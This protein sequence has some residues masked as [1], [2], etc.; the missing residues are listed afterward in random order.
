MLA[1]LDDPA[2]SGHTA[3]HVQKFM[4]HILT[5][6]CVT[7]EE[8][9][10]TEALRSVKASGIGASG[11]TSLT[12]LA[13]AAVDINL[14]SSADVDA[15]RS[16][17]NDFRSVMM[18]IFT[19]DMEEDVATKRAAL[20]QMLGKPGVDAVKAYHDEE[21]DEYHDRSTLISAVFDVRCI[22]NCP[23]LEPNNDWK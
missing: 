3:Q 12:L 22:I 5:A 16:H 17:M 20:L 9:L 6:A 10:D 15:C 19:E 7:A 13:M 8:D 21:A 18:A 4:Q 23:C 1:P 2:G 11:V 14:Q